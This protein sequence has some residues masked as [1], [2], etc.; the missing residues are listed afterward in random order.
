MVLSMRWSGCT[1]V[2]RCPDELPR[3]DDT[4]GSSPAFQTSSKRESAQ[5]S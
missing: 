4:F 1:R 3:A 5:Q 2:S